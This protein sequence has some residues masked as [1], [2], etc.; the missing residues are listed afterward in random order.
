MKRVTENVYVEDRYSAQPYNRGCNPGYITT[1]EG[2]VL[3][4]TPMLPRD[5][6]KWRDQIAKL[7]KVRYIINTHFHADH[8][9]GNYLFN[10]PIIAHEGDR[11]LSKKL[12]T[13]IFI[14]GVLKKSKGRPLTLEETARFDIEDRDPESIPFMKDFYLKPPDIT[15]SEGL[16]LYVG[17]HTF[18]CTHLPGH[19]ATHIGV[20][21][22]QEKVFFAG[23]NFTNQVQPVLSSC[24][25]FEWVASLKKIE[26]MDVEQVIPGHGIVGGKKEVREFRLFIEKCLEMVRDAIKKGMSKEQAASEISFESL[27]PAVHPG[28]EQQ[29]FNVIRLYEA[30]LEQAK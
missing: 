20:Y 19:V 23:D 15:F 25:P 30:W 12:L 9:S 7:G 3:I 21:I 17:N 8:T 22:P 2:I 14:P 18:V 13:G 4:D 27:Y 29:S 24:L 28:A 1:S 10:A 11:E 5:A 16:T 26:A 6:I